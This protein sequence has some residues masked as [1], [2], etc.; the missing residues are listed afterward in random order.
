VIPRHD[1]DGVLLDWFEADA[2]APP[3]AGGLDKVLDATTR[4]RPR[5]A[6]L[7]RPGSWWVGGGLG[8]P[9]VLHPAARSI[10]ALVFLLALLVAM[11]VV[12]AALTQP[13]PSPSGRF[14]YALDGDIYLA[15]ADG[16]DPVRITGGASDGP[17]ATCGGVGG[18]GPM[19][20]PDGRHLAY[21]THWGDECPGRV[22]IADPT[23]HVVASVPGSGWVVAW[24]PDSTRFATWD[25]LGRTIGVYGLD[26][27]R[28][29]LLTVPPGLMA[30]G[31][32]DPTWSPDGTSLV[33]PH[34]VLVPLDGSA[35]TRL[36]QD[37]PRS[38]RLAAY[39]T[40]GTQVVFGDADGSLSIAAVGGLERRRLLPGVAA[41]SHLIW[42]PDGDR[43]A[44]QASNRP[45][46]PALSRVLIVDLASGEATVLLESEPPASAD[47]IRFSPDGDQ[48]LLSVTGADGE[49]A[50]QSIRTDGSDRHVLVAGTAWGDWQPASTGP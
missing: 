36:S 21:R 44:Y 47:P 41:Y 14:A 3:P 13:T 48:V 37:D 40:D 46:T 45:G 19:W 34:G 32:F 25:D 24:A 22:I 28:E 29:V 42:S 5:A 11:I 15:D 23:G 38:A 26:G 12:G 2:Q 39:S 31:D 27:A 18:D 43:I 49:D 16:T 35:P 30:P 7:A 20:A 17:L 6:W 50:L 4:R 10:L 8:A 9:A 33:V 1:L